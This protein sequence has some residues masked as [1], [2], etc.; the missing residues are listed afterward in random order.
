MRSVGYRLCRIHVILDT[1][2]TEVCYNGIGNIRGKDTGC[3]VLCT[4][5][6]ITKFSLPNPRKPPYLDDITH[7]FCFDLRVY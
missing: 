7:E 4:D 2:T 5:I 6:L 3:T 1:L